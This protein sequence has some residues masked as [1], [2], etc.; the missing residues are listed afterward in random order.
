MVG[1]QRD[2]TVF[3]NVFIGQ[4]GPVDFWGA[5]LITLAF[6][7]MLI[8]VLMPRLRSQLNLR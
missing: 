7:L 3:E 2:S 8:A 5:S 4:I 6:S 1:V